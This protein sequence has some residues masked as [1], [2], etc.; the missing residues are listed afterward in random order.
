MFGLPGEYIAPTL[1]GISVLCLANQK[2]VW[3]TRVFGG[4]VGNEGLGA[5]SLCF[6]WAYVG[7]GGSSIGSMFTPLATQLS[8]YAGYTVCMIA[9][10]AC[11]SPNTW[12]TQ[13]FPRLL[14]YENGTEYDQLSIL[15]GAPD[16]L[17]NCKIITLA[18]DDFTLNYDRLAVQGL[19]WY[20]ASQLL[21]KVSRTIY[22]GAGLTHFLLWHGKRV[23]KL[24]RADRE[25]IDDPHFKKMKAYPGETFL[26][27][28]SCINSSTTV[29]SG[30][31]S[32]KVDLCYIQ[33]TFISGSCLWKQEPQ[34]QR[35]EQAPRQE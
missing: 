3:F 18:A 7:T 25:G 34:V 23:Y 27:V 26:H 14:Y 35:Q 13:N 30:S 11:H 5:F 1:T 24:I 8:L 33:A 4:A 20:A 17:S 22:I 29:M 16:H 32:N 19:P 31:Q 2:L 15:N 12:K 6:D 10:C 9:F 21:Y 28:A